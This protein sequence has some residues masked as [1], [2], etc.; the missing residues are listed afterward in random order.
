MRLQEAPQITK[1]YRRRYE[2]ELV[3]RPV[4]GVIRQHR[5]EL[6]GKYRFERPMRVLPRF[7]G[8]S[9]LANRLVDARGLVSTLLMARRIVQYGIGP[10]DD[11]QIP[12]SAKRFQYAGAASISD[13]NPSSGGFHRAFL[14]V[15]S[16]AGQ[17]T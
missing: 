12:A 10:A 1:H 14:F 13:E 11:V 17:G 2:N 4:L 15:Q 6:T 7:N 3:E 5:P 9:R 16:I 8:M